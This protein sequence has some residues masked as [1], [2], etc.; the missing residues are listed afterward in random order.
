M[1]MF[2]CSY[3]TTICM[4]QTCISALM[5][6]SFRFMITSSMATDES[7]LV[8]F[9]SYVNWIGIISRIITWEGD[10]FAYSRYES[11]RSHSYLGNLSF[12]VSLDLSN[13]SFHGILPHELSKLHRLKSLDWRENK[14]GG[15]FLS[16]LSS[17]S[18]LHLL[19]LS[20][21]TFSGPIPA[22]IA[23]FSKL[24][25]LR[26]RL[27]SFKG[28]I[29]QEMGYLCALTFLNLET[30]LLTWPIPLSIFNI[31]TLEMIGLLLTNLTGKFRLVMQRHSEPGGSA[32]FKQFVTWIN[33]SKF[34]KMWQARSAVPKR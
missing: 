24:Q 28:K 3:Y 33:T 2:S 13:N 34:T 25:E 29:P 26:L 4:Y 20:R 1:L 17:L 18:E 22:T 12:L 23:N 31:S 19:D 14:L 8:A 11:P 27:N 10:S 32:S 30:N 16:F 7:A 5:F 15:P 9:K 6:L 21:N